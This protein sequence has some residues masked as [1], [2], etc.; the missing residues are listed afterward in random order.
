MV[1][2]EEFRIIILIILLIVY[3][4]GK[5]KHLICFN[6]RRNLICVHVGK[7]R[8]GALIVFTEEN[9]AT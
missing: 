7:P 5:S 1:W 8:A 4:L 2:Y 3:I 6:K 9:S